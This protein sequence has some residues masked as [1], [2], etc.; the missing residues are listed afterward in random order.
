MK[1]PLL[2]RIERKIGRYAPRNLMLVIVIGKAVVWLLETIVAQRAGVF[3]T[4]WLY[5]DKAAI[6]RGEVWRVLTFIF[7]PD[8]YS[9][10]T[11]AL[12]LYFYWWI[13]SSLESVWGSFR[14]DA[15][16]LCGVVGAI[17]GGF[18]TGYATNSYLNMSLFLAFAILFPDV[19]VL[20]FFF[21]PVKMKWLGILDAVS[22]T[23]TLIFG[24]WPIRI[25]VLLSL[26]N[27]LLFVWRIPIDKIHNA[28]RRR[29]WKKAASRPNEDEYPFDL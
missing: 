21:I 1:Q 3:I 20:L 17:I 4:D 26:L 27:L 23:L 2:D 19:Q 14:F 7:L 29:K 22:L 25:L 11:L 5:F 9:L 16:Y 10:F 6:L 13:G 24:S 18:I 8:S 28:Y 15:Y 12:S